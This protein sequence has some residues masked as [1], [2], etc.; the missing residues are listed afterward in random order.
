MIIGKRDKH[1]LSIGTLLT[2]T[3]FKIPYSRCTIPGLMCKY[4]FEIRQR[5][6]EII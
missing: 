5:S 2:L 3:I 1:N 6:V 4:V